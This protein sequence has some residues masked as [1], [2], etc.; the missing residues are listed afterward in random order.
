MQD[1]QQEKINAAREL[2]EDQAKNH[3]QDSNP[4]IS[5]DNKKG[6]LDAHFQQALNAL[7]ENSDEET[8]RRWKNITVTVQHSK[9]IT[10]F[11]APTSTEDESTADAAMDHSAASHESNP[12]LEEAEDLGNEEN[13]F[14]KTINKDGNTTYTPN[15]KADQQQALN[16]IIADIITN[17]PDASE[18]GIELIIMGR[19]NPSD[20]FLDKLKK[21]AKENNV[22]LTIKNSAGEVLRDVPKADNDTTLNL[23]REPKKGNG[24]TPP[25][26]LT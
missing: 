12:T 14:T 23:P 8:K 6:L 19:K 13:L 10:E 25:P 20:A 7:R 18:N 9:H 5:I 24:S 26:K 3:F 11:N 15:A 1:E 22:Q 4:E 2:L 17:N 21:A 16:A